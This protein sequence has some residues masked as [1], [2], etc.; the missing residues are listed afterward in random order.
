MDFKPGNLYHVYNQG[1]NR[2]PICLSSEDYLIFTK[3]TRRH[4]LPHAEIVAWCLMPNHFHFMIYADDRC[5]LIKKQ[6][7]IVIDPITNGIRKLLSSYAR[8]FNNN[9]KRTGSL[10]K[11]KTH[12]NSLTDMSMDLRAKQNLRPEEY[13]AACFHYIHQNPVRADLVKKMEDWH[14]SS[15]R[16]YAGLR[17]GTLCNKELASKFCLYNAETFIFNSNNVLRNNIIKFSH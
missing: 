2:Q 5:L 15:F 7:G 13:Y 17:S 11:Q 1:N 14:Y 3:L 8:I 10:F 9:Y 16:D 6:G 12:A 4:L